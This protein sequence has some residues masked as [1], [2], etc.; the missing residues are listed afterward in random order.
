MVHSYFVAAGKVS[1][2]FCRKKIKHFLPL[3][4]IVYFDVDIKL[5]SNFSYTIPLS[6]P[7]DALFGLGRN[8]S[9]LF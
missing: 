4:F 6:S 9:G 7:D 1:S 5:V 3:Y 2:V 8:M